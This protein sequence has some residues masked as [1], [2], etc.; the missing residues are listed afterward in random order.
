MFLWSRRLFREEVEQEEEEEFSWSVEGVK[1]GINCV[2]SPKRSWRWWP[3]IMRR[4]APTHLLLL[5]LSLSY[6]LFFS[7]ILSYSLL[8]S[9]ILSYSLSLSL[10][11]S[12]CLSFFL[13]FL[14][15]FVLF[16]SAFF[17]SSSSFSLFL[18]YILLNHI[19]GRL[20]V[21]APPILASISNSIHLLP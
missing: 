13:S 16:D 10:S 3:H 4:L 7:L 20:S 19:C 5:F 11:L 15:K 9:L 14:T 21:K 18:F 1:K 2:A 12:L 17:L 8:F 6:S